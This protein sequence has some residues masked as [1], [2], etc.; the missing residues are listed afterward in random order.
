KRLVAAAV[1]GPVPGL[2]PELAAAAAAQVR[3]GE[4][5]VRQYGGM[6]ERFL[7]SPREWNLVDHRGEFQF[8]AI[9]AFLRKAHVCEPLLLQHYQALF[10]AHA[11]TLH[12]PASVQEVGADAAR[13]ASFLFNPLP[14]PP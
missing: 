4:E 5:E 11:L 8:N 14:P 9:F 2:P 1:T 6:L 12:G 10:F 7:E 3:V 13:A